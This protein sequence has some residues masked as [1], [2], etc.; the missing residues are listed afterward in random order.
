MTVAINAVT[1]TR[2]GLRLGGARL[3][4]GTTPDVLDLVHSA[5]LG[6]A[7]TALGWR[8]DGGGHGGPLSFGKLNGRQRRQVEAALRRILPDVPAV[9]RV[10]G[11]I[12]ARGPPLLAG[13]E[14]VEVGELAL[15]DELVAGGMTRDAAVR[16]VDALVMYSVRAGTTNTYVVFS[17]WV[18]PLLARGLLDDAVAH[19]RMHLD[20]TFDRAGGHARHTQE[21]AAGAGGGPADAGAPGGD[22]GGRVRA[23]RDRAG[24][25]R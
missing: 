8:R 14:L 2:W 6:G 19:E 5:V 22:R 25:D 12:T 18:G 1:E 21:R 20:G 3:F 23:R 9:Q 24:A 16:V 7:L 17:R 13:E 15:L 4:P 10:V 11:P